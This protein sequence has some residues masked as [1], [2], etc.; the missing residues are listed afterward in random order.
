MSRE[1]QLLLSLLVPHQVGWVGHLSWVEIPLSLSRPIEKTRN[2]S[3][4]STFAA[5]LL[6]FLARTNYFSSWNFNV[7]WS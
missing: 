7:S 1:R 4:G 3:K 6:F 5:I 2:C